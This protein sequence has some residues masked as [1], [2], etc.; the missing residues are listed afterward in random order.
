MTARLVSALALAGVLATSL[1]AARGADRIA[2]PE[3]YRAW[4]HVKSMVI[5][6]RAHPLF[7]AF[8]RL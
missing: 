3:G 8:A 1:T 5:H 4:T 6:D 7:D 2:Y